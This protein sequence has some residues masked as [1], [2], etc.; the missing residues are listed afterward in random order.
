VRV[1]R[2]IRDA[3][4]NLQFRLQRAQTDFKNRRAETAANITK[5]NNRRAYE[6]V[7]RDDRLIGEYLEPAR[8]AFYEEVAAMVAPNCSGGAVI[9]IGCGAGKLLQDVVGRATPARVV[10]VDYA[11][12]GVERARRAVPSGEFH[13]CS[14]YELDLQETF[15][16]VLCTEVLEHLS[17]PEAAMRI[18]VRLCA[19]DGVIVITVPDGEY[20]SWAG[21]RNF[22]SEPELVRFLAPHGEVEV[23]RLRSDPTSL[24]ARVRPGAG[25]P[26]AG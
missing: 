13:S 10:G 16:V 25:R 24:L 2:L 18:L 1:Y 14:L 7:Y 22:W 20:D 19:D 26:D 4:L 11:V 9:D 21:H 23:S 8:L 15:D 6:R 3:K 17:K 5:R 12:A